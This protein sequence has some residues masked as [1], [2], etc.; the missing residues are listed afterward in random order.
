MNEHD[1]LVIQNTLEEHGFNKPACFVLKNYVEEMR[2]YRE[3]NIKFKN[4][5]IC[6]N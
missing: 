5:E 2:K 1:L 6:F 4:F 3:Y